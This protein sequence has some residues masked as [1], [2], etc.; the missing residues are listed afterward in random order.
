M[1]I[2]HVIKTDQ[3][4]CARSAPLRINFVVSLCSQQFNYRQTSC[5]VVCRRPT[6]SFQPVQHFSKYSNT[7][8]SKH[9]SSCSAIR[10]NYQ[11]QPQLMGFTLYQRVHRSRGIGWRLVL[12]V[13][14]AVIG[15]Y[16]RNMRR[17]IIFY[18]TQTKQSYNFSIFSVFNLYKRSFVNN[19]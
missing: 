8:L 5:R 6:M 14:N 4:R 18:E 16:L 3:W 10:P 11:S 12:L 15:G 2:N 1:R 13:I 9:A 7:P 19:S 17:S